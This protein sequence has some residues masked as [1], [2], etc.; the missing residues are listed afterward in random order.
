MREILIRWIVRTAFQKNKLLIRRF[1]GDEDIVSEREAKKLV[2][3]K[4]AEIL[5]DREIPEVS[6]YNS[7]DSWGNYEYNNS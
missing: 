4:M 7:I 3:L 6:D 2:G 5:E 1:P